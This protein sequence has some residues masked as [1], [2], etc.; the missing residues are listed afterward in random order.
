MYSLYYRVLCCSSD[1]CA[2]YLDYSAALT[3]TLHDL[4]APTGLVTAMSSRQ[5]SKSNG[6]AHVISACLQP[7]IQPHRPV[8]I[9]ST[10]PIKPAKPTHPRNLRTETPHDV[11]Q[12]RLFTSQLP[13]S[14]TPQ[15]PIVVLLIRPACYHWS[16]CF[17][18]SLTVTLLMSQFFLPSQFPQNAIFNRLFPNQIPLSS[19]PQEP[20]VALPIIFARYLQSA[21]FAFSLTEK[22][23]RPSS[24]FQVNLQK[25]PFSTIFF[26]ARFPV[27]LTS[28]P[29]GSAP[30]QYHSLQETSFLLPRLHGNYILVPVLPSKPISTKCHFRPSFSNPDS[31][32]YQS[33]PFNPR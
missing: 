5:P 7:L 20:M 27:L 12:S 28:G 24:S 33:L 29:S 23:S 10:L 25:I 4:E 13:L 16:A 31:H 1:L 15:E 6:G 8:P 19:S 11:I 14:Y 9:G 2:A 32:S 22:Y 21:V 3:Q 30:D 26:Q 17:S 18:L